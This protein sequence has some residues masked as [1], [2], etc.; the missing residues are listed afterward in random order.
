MTDRTLV[1]CASAVC[2][3]PAADAFAYLS[4]AE[5]IGEWSLGCWETRY[6]GDEIVRGTSLLDGASTYVKV[7]P[8]AECQTVDYEVGAEPERLVRRISA[9]VVAGEDLGGDP[10]RSLLILLAWRTD[11][12]DDDR[13]RRLVAAHEAEVLL[14]RERIQRSV[15]A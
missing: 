15:A 12:M 9:R 10:R 2:E 8:V 1:H 14:L 4:D 13:W 11:S 3:T 6:A 7:Q 5:R